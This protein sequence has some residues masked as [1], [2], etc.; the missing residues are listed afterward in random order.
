M[1]SL[2]NQLVVRISFEKRIFKAKL[3]IN[4]TNYF[5]GFC[6]HTLEIANRGFANIPSKLTLDDI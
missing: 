2:W 4:T 6:A 1:L 3:K 5:K